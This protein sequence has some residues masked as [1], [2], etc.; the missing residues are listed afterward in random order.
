ML[1]EVVLNCPG[2]LFGTVLI[3]FFL[4]PLLLCTECP[5]G[6]C[7]VGVLQGFWVSCRVVLCIVEVSYRVVLYIRFCRP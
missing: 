3:I 4:L 2:N 7:R 6:Q 5:A 1:V